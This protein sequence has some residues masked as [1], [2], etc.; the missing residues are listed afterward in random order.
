MSAQ[1]EE[2]HEKHMSLQQ[3]V[4][5]KS[6]T[7]QHLIS[8]AVN[9]DEQIGA[10]E[11]AMREV[12]ATH[13]Q[14]MASVNADVNEHAAQVE[15]HKRKQRNL[16]NMSQAEL[17]TAMSQAN[18]AQNDVIYHQQR[19]DNSADAHR[20]STQ[21][22]NDVSSINN[23]HAN[24]LARLSGDL[25]HHQTMNENL[26]E[27][28]GKHKVLF[29]DAVKKS[30][31]YQR[32][33]EEHEAH[34]YKTQAALES[35]L[36]GLLA[37]TDELQ[38]L[39]SDHKLNAK[40]QAARWGDIIIVKMRDIETIGDTIKETES[41]N[42]KLATVAT[43]YEALLETLV[44]NSKDPYVDD[45]EDED[46]TVIENDSNKISNEDIIN[47]LSFARCAAYVLDPSDVVDFATKHGLEIDSNVIN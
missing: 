38:N 6:V 34:A 15:S 12:T 29:G 19:H 7:L 14:E 8:T 17:A 39:H 46:A 35:D 2:R 9:L 32:L 21:D 27:E 28:H 26:I 37:S 4:G 10:F 33:M 40:E 25:S 18:K 22:L 43:Q 36:Q 20:Q 45:Y 42:L 44:E 30:A 13:Q 24:N 47:Y 11:Q 16:A 5:E 1:F 23:A 31:E 41:Q 3:E